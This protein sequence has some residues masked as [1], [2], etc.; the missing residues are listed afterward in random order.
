MTIILVHPNGKEEEL[1]NWK[2]ELPKIKPPKQ[3]R[4]NHGGRHK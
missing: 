4:Q 2:I 3:G 1:K